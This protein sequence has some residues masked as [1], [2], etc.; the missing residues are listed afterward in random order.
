MVAS[1]KSSLRSPVDPD[2][3]RMSIG[4][5]LEELRRRM[6][7][8]IGGFLAVLIVCLCFRTSVA[9]AFCQPLV[10]ALAANRISPQL[11]VHELSE[12]FMVYIRISVISALAIA[13]P[14][15]LFQ[16]WL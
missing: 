16:L 15:I 4:E 13:S 10:D 14:W 3:Y 5:H 1:I 6:I 2:Q 11:V 8:A 7:L 12:G 9:T